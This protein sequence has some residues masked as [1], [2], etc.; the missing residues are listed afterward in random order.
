MF[1]PLCPFSNR[2]HHA[3]SYCEAVISGQLKKPE[4]FAKFSYLSFHAYGLFFLSSTS[5]Q[6]GEFP[7]GWR[8]VPGVDSGASRMLPPFIKEGWG[9][10]WR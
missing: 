8:N 10:F 9:G 6:S 3:F 2:T 4:I 1:S 5:A 7:M